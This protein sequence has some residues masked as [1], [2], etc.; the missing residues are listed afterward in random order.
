MVILLMTLQSTHICQVPF[1]LRTKITRMAQG[2]RHS[3]TYP[4]SKSSWT[5]HWIFLV[6]SELVLY[7]AR[8]GNVAPGIKSIWC[9]IPLKGGSLGGILVGKTSLNSY[10]RLVIAW[11]KGVEIP[12]S[13]NKTCLHT[14]SWKGAS[15]VAGPKRSDRVASKAWL[16]NLIALELEGGAIWSCWFSDSHLTVSAIVTPGF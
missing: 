12:S 1:F 7:A 13:K 8:F 5:C 6:S 11:H 15:T 14:K 9:L 2:L 3:C 16:F 4:W 10:K